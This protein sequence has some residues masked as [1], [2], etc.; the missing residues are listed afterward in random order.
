LC[1]ISIE[2]LLN[3]EKKQPG[4]LLFS[5]EISM[6]GIAATELATDQ[7]ARILNAVAARL[8]IVRTGP[9]HVQ[10]G[11][12]LLA[13]LVPSALDLDVSDLAD[14]AVDI[15][16]VAKDMFLSNDDAFPVPAPEGLTDPGDFSG[17]QLLGDHASAFD[18]GRPFVQPPLVTSIPGVVTQKVPGLLG[19][20]FGTVKLPN[21]RVSLELTWRIART[22]GTVIEEGSDFIGLN[23]LSNPAAAITVAPTISEYRHDSLLNPG[24]DQYCLW[25]EVTL[26]LG[27][28]AHATT[29][30]PLPYVQLPILVPTVVGLFSEPNFDVNTSSAA[31]L[32]V[33]EHSPF[34]SLEPLLKLL[35]T[36]D[37][38]VSSLRSIGKLAGFLLGLSDVL[39]A[40]PQTPRLRLTAK[41]RIDDLENYE[42]KPR[43][44]YNIF[45][46]ADTFDDRVNS[47]FVLGA[48][49]TEVEFFNDEDCEMTDQG[50]YTVRLNTSAT[51]A[52]DLPDTFVAI[53]TLYAPNP[54]PPPTM[55][56]GRIS[57]FVEDTT[58]DGS[59]DT[60][61]TSLRFADNFINE[62][63]EAIKRGG[64]AFPDLPCMALVL[65]KRPQPQ[66]GKG[67]KPDGK[68]R[69]PKAKR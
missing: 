45:A 11:E 48:P 65:P 16:G 35:E 51:L 49:G 27:S 4:A 19:Q 22:D 59:W 61:L 1:S 52:G 55:P 57:S 30:G 7:A 43:P 2:N 3:R 66:R 12:S 63:E 69:R 8:R 67:T 60:D 17:T 23:G 13:Q 37:R 54:S 53:P 47:I 36:I 44:W 33:P 21:V 58:G 46:S 64:P 5:W 50:G 10:P 20:V 26:R 6:S 24:G 42:I 14:L 18:G 32:V 40:I 68:P 9:R 29:L 38:T 15:G 39:G 62:V 28:A 25:L 41:N 31:L 34:V 56:P